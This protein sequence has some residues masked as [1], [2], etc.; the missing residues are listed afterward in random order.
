MQPRKP[1][2]LALRGGEDFVEQI[3]RIASE[4]YGAVV[5]DELQGPRDMI[6]TTRSMHTS[7]SVQ[8]YMEE[9]LGPVGSPLNTR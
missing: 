1:R 8:E 3:Q 5:N 2:R 9:K 7:R 4:P 6:L